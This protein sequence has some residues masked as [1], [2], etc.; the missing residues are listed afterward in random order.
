MQE[1]VLIEEINAGDKVIGVATLNSEKSLN[2]LSLAMAEKLLPQL[3]QWANDERV[4]CVWL[5]GAGDKA[6]CAGGDIVAMYKAM[7]AEPGKLVPEV[8]NFFTHEYQLDYA[9]QSF[10][11]P[12][13]CWADGIVM[14][15]GMGLMNGASH[16]IVT[17]R[18]LLA[19]PEVS[20][21]LYPDVGATHFL[22][23]MPAGC[24]LFLGI[25]GAPMNANDALFLKLADHYLGHQLKAATMENLQQLA[26]GDTGALNK[27]KVTDLL[28][29]M[30]VQDLTELPTPQVEPLHPHIE[31][32]TRGNEVSDVVS[33]IVDDD[34]D[35]KW[36]SRARRNLSNGCP[37][38]AHIVWNQLQQ[39]R[40]LALADCFRLELTLS[41]NC[42]VRGDFAE[43][44]RA[45][46][47]DKDKTPQWQHSSV[48]QVSAEDVDAFFIPPWGDRRHPLA[49]LEAVL[50]HS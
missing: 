40:D 27:E 41:C 6:F 7:Q 30:A 3:Q 2:A 10:P 20:I 37:M 46:L 11:K 50:S 35:D 13:I 18:S 32:L 9:I 25:T 39:G 38:T 21:G 15:G 19:M 4:V 33:A 16:R 8:E 29:Q 31:S 12:L 1:V 22:N 44:I 48:D 24:G 17:D 47:I 26:W 34:L 43:G 14:G 42:A 36:L 28:N 49:D 5:Q 23:R 45:L